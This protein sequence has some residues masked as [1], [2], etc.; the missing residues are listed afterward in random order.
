M[1]HEAIRRYIDDIRNIKL[2]R[3]E[4]LKHYIRNL[5]A[6]EGGIRKPESNDPDEIKENY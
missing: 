1:Q 2:N 6:Q 3:V 4:K 5:I